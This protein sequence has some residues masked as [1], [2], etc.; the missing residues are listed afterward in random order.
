MTSLPNRS[1]NPGRS[2]GSSGRGVEQVADGPD[3]AVTCARPD[4]QVEVGEQAQRRIA[5]SGCGPAPVPSARRSRCPPGRAGRRP[6]E[7][8]ALEAE[9]VGAPVPVQVEQLGPSV[10]VGDQTVR[11]APA[12]SRPEHPLALGQG[13]QLAPALPG[14]M[15]SAGSG[16]RARQPVRGDGRSSQR[17]DRGG[18]SEVGPA[19]VTARPRS[20]SWTAR[21][22]GACPSVGRRPV[23]AV[24]R[25]R[26]GRHREQ[27]EEQRD[28]LD[29]LAREDAEVGDG[30]ERV[31]EHGEVGRRVGDV[32]L[33]SQSGGGAPDP[34]PA[35]RR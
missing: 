30:R 25:R 18:S 16:R 15:G 28:E 21:V 19:V 9:V 1:S 13:H 14:R 5:G 22:P 29:A 6:Q 7:Q 33:S 8:Q 35:Q 17:S 34:A 27:D 2:S 11:S 31:G 12:T 10:V 32:G 3:A 24:R 26:A 4:Q 23:R 20:S